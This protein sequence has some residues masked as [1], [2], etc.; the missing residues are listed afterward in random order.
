MAVLNIF[1]NKN[2]L[3]KIISKVPSGNGEKKCISLQRI[4]ENS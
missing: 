1:M 4:I 3:D 2:F